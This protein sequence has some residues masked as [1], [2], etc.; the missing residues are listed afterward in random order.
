MAR[1]EFSSIKRIVFEPGTLFYHCT[2]VNN[3][4]L[5]YKLFMQEQKENKT[6]FVEPYFGKFSTHMGEKFFTLSSDETGYMNLHMHGISS[7]MLCYT[8]KNRLTLTVNHGLTRND[9]VEKAVAEG[10][11][12]YM[13]MCDSWEVCVFNAS[14]FFD[15]FVIVLQS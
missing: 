10:S 6:D 2:I 13:E 4:T 5:A 14:K 9:I 15:D 3:G 12:G 7:V 8:L 1:K 11:D